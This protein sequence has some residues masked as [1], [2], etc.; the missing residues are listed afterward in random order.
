MS[1][2]FFT[3]IFFCWKKPY[4]VKTSSKIDVLR[5]WFL[6]LKKHISYC[7]ELR[8]NSSLRPLF[9]EGNGN[10][11]QYSSWENSM[12]RGI[13]QA[14]IHGIA[15]ELDRTEPLTPT[16]KAFI[17]CMSKLRLT[18]LCDLLK[19]THLVSADIRNHILLL[20]V[21]YLFSKQ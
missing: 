5:F 14:T 4:L 9:G 7:V 16:H 10:P 2:F 17:V 6:A 21:S 1:F 18:K 13:W 8:N 19:V 11:L 20:L 3:E 12:D 15:K